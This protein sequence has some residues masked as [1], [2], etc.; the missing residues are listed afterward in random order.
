MLGF[1]HTPFDMVLLGTIVGFFAGMYAY[2]K[3]R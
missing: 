1:Y 2:P 3:V